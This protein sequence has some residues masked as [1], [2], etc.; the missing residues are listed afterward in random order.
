M[1]DKVLIVDDIEL[2][3]EMLAVVLGDEYSVLEAGDGEQA[4]EMLK[5][6]QNQI[7]ALLLDLIMPKLD[8]YAVL[9]YMKEND[10]MERIPVLIISADST[11]EA[12]R[13]CLEMGV[14]DFIRK[15]FDGKI[16]R[17]RVRNIMELFMYKNN[18]EE[19][20]KIQT[21]NLQRQN[22]ILEEQAEKIRQSNEKIV[23]IL[24]TVVEY[25]NLESGEHIKRVK[26]F[27]RIL[28]QKV[29]AKY[30]EYALTPGKIDVIVSAS[31]L[32]DIGKIAIRDSVLLKPGRLDPDEYEYIKS[33]TI[34]GCD[35]LD[36]IE[37]AWD[38][39]YERVSYNI[40][41]YHHE[42]Y[43]G[44][45]Y[46]DALVGDDIPIEAQIV[47]VADVYDALV[48]DRVYKEAIDKEK[49]FHMILMGE[50]GVFSPKIMECFR[51]SKE[52]FE[53]LVD[54]NKTE[55]KEI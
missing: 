44:N 38:H 47:S 31:A 4:I 22:R 23:D 35:I 34:R 26:G 52:E 46:P 19:K 51:L 16:V 10:L 32:H 9:K 42:R 39:E 15:P 48:S 2:N 53:Q 54:E 41:R 6:P 25:R 28:A 45:G 55:K 13:D 8:G 30:P 29:A 11:R 3:R 20:V 50:C 40:C 1:R 7:G 14:S 27:T 24:G 33:H 49:A 17:N 43:D 12:E 21:E 37:D 18:L 5:D 36:Q